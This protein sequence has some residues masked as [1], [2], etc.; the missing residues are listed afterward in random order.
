MSYAARPMGDYKTYGYAGDPGFLS[1]LWRGVKKIAPRI[2]GGLVGGPV[3]AIITGA[4][5][6]GAVVGAIGKP[7]A[8]TAPPPRINRRRRFFSRRNNRIGRR[9]TSFTCSGGS[10][11][12]C[13]LSPGQSDPLEVGAQS[14]NEHCESS[15]AAK[16]NATCAGL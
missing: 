3:G 6:G 7:R 10:P 11:R 8:P 5:V 2:I 12:T 4:T 16:G 14:Q 15:S 13:G 9:S 1:N